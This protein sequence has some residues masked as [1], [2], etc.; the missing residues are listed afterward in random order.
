[1]SEY[2]GRFVW[3]ELM[4]DDPAAAKDFYGKVLGWSF[5][6]APMPGQAGESY[7]LA[8][9]ADARVAG[10]MRLPQEAKAM[11]TPPCWSGY[12]AVDDVDA[13]ARRAGELGGKALRAPMD[14]PGIGRMAVIADPDG[15]VI[16]IFKG[17]DGSMPPPKAMSGE[18]GF[19]GWREL[20]AGDAPK[21]IGFYQDLFG[22]EKDE[23]FDMGPMGVYQ[24]F[25]VKGERTGGMMTK[26]AEIPAPFW[27]YYFTVDGI[28]AAI[29]RVKA[30]GGNIVMAPIQVPTGEWVATGMDNG[31]AY[32]GLLS[33]AK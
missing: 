22:W 31:H 7:I 10:V 13:A 29:E 32:F 9:V 21:V 14:I 27:G 12:V 1:M 16:L 11:G 19:V 28:E 26:P 3:F 6:D 17:S 2:R 4:V 24:L 18:P 5:E 30:A 23:P 33:H 15:A 8:K 20:M 25:S